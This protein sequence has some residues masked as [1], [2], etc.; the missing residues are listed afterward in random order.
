ML[1]DQFPTDGSKD[2]AH[3]HT[4]RRTTR[5]Y[6]FICYTEGSTCVHLL[7]QGASVGGG[8]RQGTTQTHS[9]LFSRHPW[10]RWRLLPPA[11]PVGNTADASSRT[12]AD[13]AMGKFSKVK[14]PGK[15]FHAFVRVIDIAKLLLQK[16]PTVWKTAC[17]SASLPTL[18][19]RPNLCRHDGCSGRLRAR[20]ACLS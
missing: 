3:T 18:T 4:S 8:S 14:L 16:L 17:F 11:V 2:T 5:H 10:R 13:S 6:A 1:C 19:E 12:C 15:R 9:G 20:P 7:T